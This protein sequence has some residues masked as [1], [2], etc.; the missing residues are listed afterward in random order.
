MLF[1]CLINDCNFEYISPQ[2]QRSKA[3]CCTAYFR[4]ML[5]VILLYSVSRLKR[6]I[7]ASA[8]GHVY[9]TLM[10]A[11]LKKNLRFCRAG[12]ILLKLYGYRIGPM[13]RLTVS[14]DLAQTQA[15]RGV[16]DYL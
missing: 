5:L 11:S 1:R 2:I 15:C 14:S 12:L 3:L 4:K 16:V 8:A 13:R 6:G 10:S 9:S 7:A